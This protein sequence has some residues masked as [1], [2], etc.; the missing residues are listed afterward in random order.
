MNWALDANAC[1]AFMRGRSVAMKTALL[2]VEPGRVFVPSIVRAELLTGAL[3]SKRPERVLGETR[4]FLRPFGTLA[5]DDTCAET[6]SLLRHDLVRRG[7]S[8]GPNDLV[9][10]ATTHAHGA[11]LVTHN[12]R[13]FRRVPGLLYEDWEGGE[14]PGVGLTRR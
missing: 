12:V 11:V 5:F 6:Y 9:L 2:S 13:E 14:T 3:K 1:I 4:S 8:I 10:A 7:L